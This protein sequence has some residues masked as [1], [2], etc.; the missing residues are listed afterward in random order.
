MMRRGSYTPVHLSNG[1]S[2]M[3]AISVVG[4]QSIVQSFC[5]R[6]VL[7]KVPKLGYIIVHP[8]P[9][10][11]ALARRRKSGAESGPAAGLARL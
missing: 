4:R 8:R 9:A 6:F 2:F 7:D 11:G 1:V 3:Q 10:R 5:S